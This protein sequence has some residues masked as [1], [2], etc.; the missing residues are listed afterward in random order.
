MVVGVS[1]GFTKILV[2][3][4]T[5]YRSSVAGSELTLNVGYSNPRVLA[6]PEGVKVTVGSR[7]CRGRPALRQ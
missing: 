4:G 7:C 3:V 5:G 1:D 2:M 6:I